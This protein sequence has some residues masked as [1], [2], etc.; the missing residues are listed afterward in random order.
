MYA[1]DVTYYDPFCPNE[2]LKGAMKAKYTTNFYK[3]F[4]Y[5]YQNEYRFT[6]PFPGPKILHPLDIQ[7]EPLR[8]ICDLITVE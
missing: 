5:A 2:F 7:V 1:N 6:W 3:E 8:D 4:N